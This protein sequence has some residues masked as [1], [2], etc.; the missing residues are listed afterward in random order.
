MLFTSASFVFLFL[1]LSLAAFYLSPTRHRRAM[2]LLISV[3]FYILANLASPLSIVLMAAAV[4]ATYFAGLFVA[5]R[6]RDDAL[7]RRRRTVAAI[8]VLAAL[9]LFIV[10]RVIAQVTV[11]AYFPLGAAIWL[12]HCVSY[13]VDIAR[14]DVAPGHPL[15]SLL[16]LTCFPLLVIGP[17][18][19][20]KV[21]LRALEQ[22][23]CSVNRIADG[24]RSF[25]VGF[26]EKLAVSAV[27]LDAYDRILGN[28]VGSLNLTLG[29]CAAVLIFVIGF[30]S[31]SGLSCMAHGL[32]LMFGLDFDEDIG[33]M[34]TARTPGEYFSRCFCGLGQWLDDYLC[35]PLLARLERLGLR[36]GERTSAALRGG[37]GV[38]WLAVWLKCSP[39]LLLT[40]LAIGVI[41]ALLAL[42]GADRAI[43][44]HRWLWPLG[45]L[46]TFCVATVFWTSGIAG[47]TASLLQLAGSLTVSTS[48]LSIYY[49]Y[50]EMSGGRYPASL[51][52]A[53]LMIPM[54]HRYNT[55]ASLLPRGL[56][57]V[58]DGVRTVIILGLFAFSLLFYL[59]Q[60]PE[61]ALMALK[62]FSF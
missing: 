62:H 50:I 9:A 53:L 29:L 34:L 25:A 1:P 15:D 40:G 22:M 56:R 12:L 39:S 2:L 60:Y 43:L 41:V 46:L 23:N 14:G 52:I 42:S 20:Y 24:M 59:P 30:F 57:S 45:W 10:L 13:I 4:T 7:G 6:V 36:I 5:P 28:G 51:G 44:R 27:L 61:Y 38:V 37:L 33:S 21:F 35:S 17:V 55:V 11:S 31:L 49:I 26:V 18:V 16:Y 19:R 54:Y 32:A 48:E 58:Y 47:S 8:G 3:A